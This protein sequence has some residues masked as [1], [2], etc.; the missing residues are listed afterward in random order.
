MTTEGGIAVIGTGTVAPAAPGSLPIDPEATV[1]IDG[2][3]ESGH[4]RCIYPGEF[5]RH[6]Q[7]ETVEELLPKIVAQIRARHGVEVVEFTSVPSTLE[8]G[9]VVAISVGGAA[10]GE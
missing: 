6:H 4:I 3:D 7:A 9:G 10:D 1:T 5:V 2:I 8:P